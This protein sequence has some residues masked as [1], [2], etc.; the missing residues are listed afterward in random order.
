MPALEGVPA[1][2]EGVPA[3]QGEGVP[4][5]GGG[6]CLLPGGCLVWGVPVW[7]VPAP[8]GSLV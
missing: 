2:G 1:L 6:V 3:P 8:R 4:A 5:P 7:G